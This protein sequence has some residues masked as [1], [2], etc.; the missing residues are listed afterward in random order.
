MAR[1]VRVKDVEYRRD[2]LFANKDKGD[3][4]RRAPKFM[5][6]L[7]TYSI[8]L[9]SYIKKNPVGSPYYVTQKMY[10]EIIKQYFLVGLEMIYTYKIF[11]IK[12]PI[13]KGF[14]HI[15]K[16]DNIKESRKHLFK[17]FTKLKETGKI[18]EYSNEHTNGFLFYFR[19]SSNDVARRYFRPLQY[20]VFVA[21]R[22]L[23]RRLAK[24][25]KENKFDTTSI[26]L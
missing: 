13:L 14:V 19:Y 17:D 2:I 1:K 5:T 24:E 7:S 6:D 12:I 25:I 4:R 3:Q 16:K 10:A 22:P 26:W 11:E 8:Y 21:A 20:Y 9:L 23:K 18:T 15:N